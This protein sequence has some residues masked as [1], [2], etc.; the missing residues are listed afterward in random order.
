MTKIK[1][2][3]VALSAIVLFAANSFAGTVNN[4]VS[5]IYYPA[6]EPMAELMTVNYLGE[7]ADYLIFRSICKSRQQQNS[8]F[9]CERQGRR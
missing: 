3:A 2:I 7:D 8:F 9:C 6:D 5:G 1:N 4:S